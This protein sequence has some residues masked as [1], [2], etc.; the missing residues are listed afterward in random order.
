MSLLLTQAAFTCEK[1]AEPSPD[2]GCSTGATLR[3]L[4]GLDGCK[5]VLELDNKERLEPAGPEW[6]SFT[7]VDGMRVTV[8]YSEESR[9][10]V[11]MVGKTVRLHCIQPIQRCGTPPRGN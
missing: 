5:Y 3:N 1:S 6:Q 11:C 7:K 8:S 10:S 2:K 9:V 4:T